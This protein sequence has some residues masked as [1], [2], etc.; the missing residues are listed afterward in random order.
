MIRV[1]GTSVSVGGEG[2]LLRGPSGSGKSDLALRLVDEGARLVADDQTEVARRDSSIEM[3][4]PATLAGLI[5][6]RGL[7]I[8]R[9]PHVAWA[10][11]RLVVDLVPDSAI[12]RMPEPSFCT[13]EGVSLPLLAVDPF[14]ASAPAKLRLALKTLAPAGTVTAP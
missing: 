11:L 9:V 7:G 4:A 13:I 2:I 3:S 12:E 8:V 14:A 6:V 1:H 10:P 5:E